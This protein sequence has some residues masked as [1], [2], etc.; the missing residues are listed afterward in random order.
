M[1]PKQLRGSMLTRDITYEAGGKRLIGTY[2]VDDE[3]AGKRPGVLVCHQGSGLRDHEKER[4]RM[5]AGLGYAAFCL[6]LY[7][8]VVTKI[9]QARPLMDELVRDPAL[10]RVRAMA[11]LQQLKAQEATDI[12]RMGAIGFCFGGT[13]VLELA[14]SAPEL[15]CVVAFHPGIAQ[16]PETDDRKVHAKVLVCTGER[17]PLIPPEAREKF[18]GLMKQGQAD[19]QLITYGNAG[20]SF[21][22]RSVDALGFPGFSYDATADKRSWAAMR[23]MFDETF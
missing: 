9:E 14:R 20:H 4:A 19:W 13:V 17:D 5:L 23:Q 15:A 10:L 22:D 2:A 1:N 21:T 7:S 6:D 8:T 12:S 3:R 16:L 11:G 18:I